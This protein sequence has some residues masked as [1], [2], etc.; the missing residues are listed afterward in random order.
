MSKVTTR[1]HFGSHWEKESK[2]HPYDKF[3]ATGKLTTCKDGS[4]E[5]TVL[6]MLSNMPSTVF[7]NFMEVLQ[8]HFPANTVVEAKDLHFTAESS[9][10][11]S[12]TADNIAMLIDGALKDF[13]RQEHLCCTRH[14]KDKR[15]IIVNHI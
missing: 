3:K 13:S 2:K 7:D 8:K 4:P 10:S 5:S 12:D 14:R 11:P 9:R 1:W 6:W 15:D